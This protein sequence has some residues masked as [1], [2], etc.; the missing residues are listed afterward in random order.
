MYPTIEDQRTGLGHSTSATSHTHDTER[1]TSQTRE[2][3]D[4]NSSPHRIELDIRSATDIN[5]SADQKCDQHT[6]FRQEHVQNPH[7]VPHRQNH[8]SHRS[9]HDH[10]PSSEQLGQLDHAAANQNLRQ[11][12]RAL[13]QQNQGVPSTLEGAQ[14]TTWSTTTPGSTENLPRK[15]V[16]DITAQDDGVTVQVL[17]RRHRSDMGTGRNIR[18]NE[19]P[20][21][22]FVEDYAPFK[23]LAHRNPWPTTNKN[24]TNIPLYAP[25][26]LPLLFSTLLDF[27]TR[28]FGQHDHSVK[29]LL[30]VQKYLEDKSTH[31]TAGTTEVRKSKLELNTIETLRNIGIIE[32]LPSNTE[33]P[34]TT[35]AFLVKEERKGSMRHRTIFHTLVDNVNGPKLQEG[36]MKVASY[37]L[38]SARLRSCEFAAT[39]DFRSYFHQLLFSPSVADCFIFQ[40]HC[41]RK[42][43][44]L[45]AAMGHKNSPAAATAITKALVLAAIH[46]SGVAN[47]K[48]D[49]IIDDV[50]FASTDPESLSTLLAAFDH[51]CQRFRVTIGAASE[52][53]TKQVHRGI[54]FDL[55]NKTQRMKKEFVEKFKTRSEFYQTH[56]T[57]S[58]AKSLMGMIAHAAQVVYLPR[59]S[60]TYIQ[61]LKALSGKCDG[62]EFIEC[63]KQILENPST[64]M[65]A[66]ETTPFGG[67]LCADATPTR[68]AAM[69]VDQHG[70]IKTAT[71]NLSTP[72]PIHIAEAKATILSITL[73]PKHKVEHVIDIISDNLT[74]LYSVSQPGRSTDPQLQEM[75]DTVDNKLR[76]INIIPNYKYITSAENPTDEMS[77][78]KNQLSDDAK[79]VDRKVKTATGIHEMSKKKSTE[80]GTR[81]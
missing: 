2:F 16:A 69:Y 34:V 13:L 1:H 32:E 49:I 68:I 54:E 7:H 46:V 20:V 40:N 52:P 70:D 71:E 51:I 3:A 12:H 81:A 10:S 28:I 43:R 56:P 4:G 23:S 38:L 8:H 65:R 79:E 15:A 50:I 58:R 9:L 11:T 42:F 25:S 33:L 61:L 24:T 27:I 35:V 77:R 47:A 55:L 59:L 72:L 5:H 21:D 57:A 78:G 31:T 45:R 44:L 30:M 18:V 36:V 22:G 17:G 60:Q 39:R 29:H 64:P 66:C 80:G 63:T 53:S 19:T 26:V 41:G 14:H 48:Y 74:W 75:R 76:E 6:A 37:N 67:T 62:H 73:V